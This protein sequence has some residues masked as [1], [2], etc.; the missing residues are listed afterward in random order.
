V[1]ADLVGTSRFWEG[2]D[3]SIILHPLKDPEFGL[4]VF[5]PFV[6]H[7]GTVSA[8]DVGLE[9]MPG[10]ML[11]PGRAALDDSMIG[12]F[13]FM[14][15]ELTIEFAVRFRTAREYDDATGDL[16]KPMH[17]KYFPKFTFQH[18][19]K[20][21]CRGIPT[22]GEDGHSGGFVENNEMVVMMKDLQHVDI[23]PQ[24]DKG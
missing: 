22:V 24:S 3:Q 11:I 23:K 6:H 18:V 21:G 5:T 16:I 15:F 14:H 2:F 7:D 19:A 12:F 4:R 1:D 8:T 17:Y 20:V 13:N 9:H 10:S